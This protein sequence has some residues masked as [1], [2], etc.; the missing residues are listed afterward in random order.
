M[1]VF[2]F[3]YSFFNLIMHS[4]VTS[5]SYSPS[6]SAC[7]RLIK[8]SAAICCWNKWIDTLVET[9]VNSSGGFSASLT[10]PLAQ[11]WMRNYVLFCFWF[12]LR[13]RRSRRMGDWTQVRILKSA[14]GEESSFCNVYCFITWVAAQLWVINLSRSRF[15]PDKLRS[16]EICSLL[17]FS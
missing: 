7:V 14:A 17:L 16:A 10:F 12:F 13:R 2:F 4:I 3:F 6:C 8:L 11:I 1:I 15:P 9:S 5:G